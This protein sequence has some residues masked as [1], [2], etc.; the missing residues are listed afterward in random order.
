MTGITM[1]DVSLKDT[2]LIGQERG[3]MYLAGS[4]GISVSE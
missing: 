4:R 3:R 2:C 1:F